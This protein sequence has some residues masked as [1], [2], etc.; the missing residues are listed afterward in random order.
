MFEFEPAL[1]LGLRGACWGL[2]DMMMNVFFPLGLSSPHF[3]MYSFTDI[4]TQ[5]YL[6]S[7]HITRKKGSTP[8]LS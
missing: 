2:F 4:T 5:M 7:C 3:R 1:L 6:L 8:V